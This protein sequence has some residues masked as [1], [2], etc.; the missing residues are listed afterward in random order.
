V[1]AFGRQTSVAGT[2]QKTRWDEQDEE[3]NRPPSRSLPPGEPLRRRQIQP[4]ARGGEARDLE[5]LT[6]T[7]AFKVDTRGPLDRL[8]RLA[9]P[10]SE[11]VAFWP[12]PSRAGRGNDPNRRCARNVPLPG[13]LRVYRPAGRNSPCARSP[14]A[15]P[16]SQKKTAPS[17]RRGPSAA[18]GFRQSHHRHVTV[19]PWERLA[20]NVNAVKRAKKATEKEP[21]LYSLVYGALADP[22]G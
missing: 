3:T 7:G 14:R 16:E 18:A 1:L 5:D 17:W 21:N 9:E 10:D 8:V 6:A 19:A 20:G 22:K 2:P 4:R 11:A 13:L 12:R 15:C